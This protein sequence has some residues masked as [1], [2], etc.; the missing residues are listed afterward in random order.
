MSK[1][2]TTVFTFVAGALAGALAGAFLSIDKLKQT[3]NELIKNVSVKKDKYNK[4]DSDEDIFSD[5]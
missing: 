1:T 2:S 4:L 5:Y 3:G